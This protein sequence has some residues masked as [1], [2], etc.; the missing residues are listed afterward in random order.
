MSL[1]VSTF[2]RAEALVVSL[3]FSFPFVI[4]LFIRRKLIGISVHFWRSFLNVKYHLLLVLIL[5]FAIVVY[6]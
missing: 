4:N 6:L 1:M 3:H 2:W 5:E